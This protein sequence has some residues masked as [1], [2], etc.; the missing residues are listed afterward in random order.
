MRKH[1]KSM[2]VGKSIIQKKGSIRY[3]PV[4]A[5]LQLGMKMSEISYGRRVESEDT[6]MGDGTRGDGSFVF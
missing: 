3:K 4:Y 5:F 6:A 1:R 2:A